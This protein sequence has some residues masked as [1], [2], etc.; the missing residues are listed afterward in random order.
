MP[1]N[2]AAYLTATQAPLEIREVDYPTPSEDE[3]IVKNRAVAI[4]PVDWFQQAK[5]PEGIPWLKFPAILG[6]D[7]AGEVEAVGSGVTKFKVGDRVAGLVNKGFQEHVLLS[8]HMAWDIPS[9]ITYEQAATLPM[10]VSVATKALFHKEYL[11]L[12]LPSA[13]PSPKHETLLIWGGSTSVGSNVIQLAVAAGYEV[14]TTASPH[15]FDYVK[16][17]GAAQVYDYN[18]PTVKDD[19]VAAFKGKKVAGA[20]ANGGVVL[21]TFPGIVEACAAVVLSTEGKKFV[22]LTMVPSFPIP[23]GVEAKFVQELRPNTE[24]ASAVFHNYLSEALA[25]GKYT[26][27]PKPEVVG[28]GLEALQGAMDILREGVSAKKIVV[29]L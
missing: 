23:E 27:A 28:T 10:G 18:S 15:S 20:I 19:L 2:K 21:P 22:A 3:I 4:N 14:I 5:G 13:S 8:E 26:I 1:S 12:D 11:G 29:S 9:S 7:I 16:E 24:L 17:L 25:G 6:Y